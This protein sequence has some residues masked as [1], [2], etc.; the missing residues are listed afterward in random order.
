MSLEACYPVCLGL[1]YFASGAIVGWLGAR[2]YYGIVTTRRSRGK[3]LS[4]P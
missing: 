4:G 1:Y 2:A 3:A